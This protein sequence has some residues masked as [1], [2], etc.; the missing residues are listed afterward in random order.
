M[1]AL[2]TY[3]DDVSRKGSS[4]T[5]A[6]SFWVK[7]K[8]SEELV[9]LKTELPAWGSIGPLLYAFGVI[10]EEQLLDGTGNCSGRR[11]SFALPNL[12]LLTNLI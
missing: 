6:L 2:N 5:V 4:E 1:Q 12:G 11:F 3:L 10:S 7:E 8:S 9:L